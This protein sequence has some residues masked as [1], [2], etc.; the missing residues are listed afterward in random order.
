EFAYQDDRIITGQNPFSVRA[1]A[2]LLI[3]QLS[4]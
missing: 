3:Q 1:V 2:R 4:K